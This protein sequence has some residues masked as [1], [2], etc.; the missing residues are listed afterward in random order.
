MPSGAST[1]AA[2]SE[3]TPVLLSIATDSDIV[4]D[5]DGEVGCDCDECDGGLVTENVD[6]SFGNIGREGSSRGISTTTGNERCSAVLP[7][8][9]C[10]NANSIGNTAWTSP[11]DDPSDIRNERTSFVV[12]AISSAQPAV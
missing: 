12:P 4:R 10:V 2:V 1:S 9:A 7:D 6:T 3:D 5:G 8:T 11:A